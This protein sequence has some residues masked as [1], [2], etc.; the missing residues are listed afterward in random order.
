[1][2][3]SSSRAGLVFTTAILLTLL[4]PALFLGY[5]VAPEASLKS[6][7]PWREL[8]GPV[9]EPSHEVFEAAT[10]LGPR[11]A[12]I[13]REPLHAALW[14]PWI[15]G[16]RPGWLVSAEEGGAPLVLVS[17]AI[18]RHGWAWTALL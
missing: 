2:Q 16:G 6:A 7:P 9:P 10:E 8:S 15:G 17:A 13:A 14:N 12:S 18:A 11:L 1:M 3:G 4:Y 5:R